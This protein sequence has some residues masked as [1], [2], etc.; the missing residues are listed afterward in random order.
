MPAGWTTA[1]CEAGTVKLPIASATT[2]VVWYST[3]AEQEM[4]L[5]R[6]ETR[7]LHEPRATQCPDLVSGQGQ[8][9]RLKYLGRHAPGDKASEVLTT[10][11]VLVTC[12]G[13]LII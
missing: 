8:V 3:S 10:S 13:A 2:R 1:A 4:V 6:F 11:P 12:N 9:L 7:L 5:T